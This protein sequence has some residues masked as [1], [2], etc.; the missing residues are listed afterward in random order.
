MGKLKVRERLTDTL[1]WAAS[2][3]VKVNLPRDGLITEMTFHVALTLSAAAVI[4]PDGPYRIIES[5]KIEGDGGRSFFGMSGE[6]MGRLWNLVNK[7]D[8][9]GAAFVNEDGLNSGTATMHIFWVFH[10]GSN[11]RDP[12]DM[13]AVIPAQDLST[14]TAEWQTTA[15]SVCDDTATI[16]SATG[17]IDICKVTGV[18]TPKGIM[19][20]LSSG[21]K[22]PHDANYSD[23]QKKIDVPTGAYLRRI[24]MLVQDATATRPVRSD[25]KVTGVSLELP[26]A[27]TTI[28]KQRWQ[29]T[30]LAG[31]LYAGGGAVQDFHTA[32]TFTTRTVVHA[33][34]AVIDLRP[35]DHPL[36]GLNLTNMQT[37]DVKLGLTIENYA[38]GDDTIIFWDQ[39]QP[40]NK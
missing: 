19:T 6:Q 30:Q 10:P 14:L 7:Y 5:F 38:S 18:P 4:Q 8:Y 17:Y 24:V 34:C 39:L 13:S 15:N 33:G 16:S 23:Y 11:P 35:Y 3:S 36:F 21:L 32:D 31:Q 40:W 29:A 2:S 22:L 25:T 9:P 26:K 20:P 27:S 12:F 28:L 1:T 37:G